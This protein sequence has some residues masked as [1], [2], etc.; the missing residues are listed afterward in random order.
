MAA[1][2]FLAQPTRITSPAS[3]VIIL[4]VRARL[5]KETEHN[6]DA[7]IGGLTTEE[8]AEVLHVSPEAVAWD[9]RLV[10]TWLRREISKL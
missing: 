3:A 9:R 5:S 6:Y 1:Q 7:Y 10:R 2:I 4:A 8:A